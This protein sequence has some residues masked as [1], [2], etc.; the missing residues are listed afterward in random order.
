M[1]L[2]QE[3]NM[4]EIAVVRQELAKHRAVSIILR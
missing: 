4:R 3:V 1:G 2:Q